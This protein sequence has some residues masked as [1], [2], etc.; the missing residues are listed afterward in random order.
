MLI[1]LGRFQPFHN[2][3]LAVVKEVMKQ[4]PGEPL[5]IGVIVLNAANSSFV[6][7]EA[8]TLDQIVM[9]KMKES[10]NPWSALARVRA[11]RRVITEELPDK[12]I[13]VIP[14]PR[15]ETDWSYFTS[16]IPDNR[17]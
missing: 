14:V 8:E 11:I 4:H 12:P 7:P 2:G 13:E 9:K 10:D 6:S 5:L 17:I 1:Q 16:L 3:H 15:P